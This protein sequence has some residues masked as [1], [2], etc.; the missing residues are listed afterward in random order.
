MLSFLGIALFFGILDQKVQAQSS[1]VSARV[2]AEVIEGIT[3]TETSQLNFGRF[4]PLEQGGQVHITA[5]GRRYAS[6]NLALSGGTFNPAS[7]RV[8]GEDGASFSIRLPSAPSV[9]RNLAN[10]KTMMVSEWE[11][12]PPAG[13]GAGILLGGA[14]A[15]SVGATLTVGNMNDNPVGIYAGTYSIVFAYN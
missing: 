11:S 5:Q 2:F 12:E 7:F 3:A 8:T 6:G 10:D 15:V 4:A 9:L 13:D 14:L 1:S